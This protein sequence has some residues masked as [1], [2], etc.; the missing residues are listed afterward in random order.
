[1]DIISHGL[2]GGVLA[3]RKTKMSFWLAFFFGVAPDLFSFGIFFVQRLFTGDLDFHKG[4]H[5]D[6]ESIAPYVNTLYNFTH[7]LV[8]FSVVFVLVW[9]FFERPIYEMFAWMFHILLDIFTHSYEFFPTPFLYPISDFK[10]NG[11][12]WGH[13]IIFFPNLILLIITYSYFYYSSRRTK[14]RGTLSETVNL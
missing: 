10:V 7:S 3:G 4:G 14:Q 6:I 8:V 9:L 2:W 1:M 11:T 13:P 12:S 5:P